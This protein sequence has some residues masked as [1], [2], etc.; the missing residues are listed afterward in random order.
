MSFSYKKKKKKKKRVD[1]GCSE[2]WI[3]LGSF[4]YGI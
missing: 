4:S 2:I 1:N 3:V